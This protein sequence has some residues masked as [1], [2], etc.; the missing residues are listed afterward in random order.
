MQRILVI[1]CPGSGKTTLARLL[2][3]ELELPVIHLDKIFWSPG[4][5]EHLSHEEFDKALLVELE[6][7]Q[8]IIEGNFDRTLAMRMAYCDSVIWLD[9]NRFTCLF[10]WIKRIVLNWGK[11]RLDMAPGC[12]ERWDWE[13][14][15]YIWDFRKNKRE[16]MYRLFNEAEGVETIVLKNRRMMRRFL[17][18]TT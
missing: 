6:K 7:P 1:G 10:G 9:Y 11:V 17:K 15:K 12:V 3:K 14:A 2:G 5:W 8:W 4:N 13:F 18:E 16:K